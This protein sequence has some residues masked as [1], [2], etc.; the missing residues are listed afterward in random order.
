M[1]LFCH[2][3]VQLFLT[4]NGT[5]GVTKWYRFVC[6][7]MVQPCHKMVQVSQNGSV[8]SQN[9]T[10]I[11]KW[12]DCHKM[13]LNRIHCILVLFC[14]KLVHHKSTKV[15]EPD[16]WEKNLNPNFGG[17]FDIFCPNFRNASKEFGDIL[18]LNSPHWYLTP[19]ENQMS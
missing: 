19:R 13:V 16:F 12:Y 3:M 2:K 15:K 9:G 4:Q 11:T 14:M 8:L 1:V 7:K 5:I 18:C 10:G 6:H 17:I